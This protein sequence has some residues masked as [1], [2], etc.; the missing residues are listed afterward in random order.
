MSVSYLPKE[1][2]LEGFAK[3][4]FV[5]VVKV[6]CWIDKLHDKCL[7]F[8]LLAVPPVTGGTTSA[9]RLNS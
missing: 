8:I 2:N 3:E 4:A 1:L 9:V 6:I 5:E 7:S